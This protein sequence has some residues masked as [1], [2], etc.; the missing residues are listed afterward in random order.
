MTEA[1]ERYLI[2]H[3]EEKALFDGTFYYW[4]NENGEATIYGA[5]EWPE[6]LVIP[7]EIDGHPVTEIGACAFDTD[8]VMERVGLVWGKPVPVEQFAT[9][10]ADIMIQED[11]RHRIKEVQLPDTIRKIGSGAFYYN[12]SLAKINFPRGL[13]EIGSCAFANADFN[14][15]LLPRECK[16]YHEEGD[17]VWQEQGAFEGCGGYDDGWIPPDPEYGIE[18]EYYED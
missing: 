11:A 6:T 12:N 9:K 15:V 18:I 13:R 14:K 10:W 16:I 1:E 3:L 2:F 7:A 4:L 5:A 8:M 17:E